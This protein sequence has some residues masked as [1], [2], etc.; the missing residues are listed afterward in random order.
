MLQKGKDELI[1]NEIIGK[2]DTDGQI[3]IKSIYEYISTVILLFPS[4]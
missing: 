2:S 4:D 3:S 1:N